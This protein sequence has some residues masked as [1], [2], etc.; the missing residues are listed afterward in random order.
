M[1]F[2]QRQTLAALARRA[3][4]RVF[5]L[6][7]AAKA[8]S[9]LFPSML[10]GVDL[11]MDLGVQ[12]LRR[13]REGRRE[14]AAAPLQE[15]GVGVASGRVGGG[16]SQLRHAAVSTVLAGL[17]RLDPL[18]ERITGPDWTRGANLVAIVDLGP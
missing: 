10:S 12:W 9:L 13:R 11:G 4:L 17:D 16:G 1:I 14:G 2:F 18:L 7:R 3:G 15:D 8:R 5:A 6:W